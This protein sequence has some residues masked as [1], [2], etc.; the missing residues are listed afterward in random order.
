MFNKK[1]T[2]QKFE[3][4]VYKLHTLNLIC[5]EAGKSENSISLFLITLKPFFLYNSSRRDEKNY[6]N[7]S[8]KYVLDI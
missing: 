2:Q 5:L 7:I 4:S 6:P 1:D 8:V 3:S